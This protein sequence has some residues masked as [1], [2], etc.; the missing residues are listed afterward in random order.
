MKDI[1]FIYQTIL[2]VANNNNFYRRML[3]NFSCNFS[4][5]NMSFTRQEN[6]S[7]CHL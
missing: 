4:L 7:R 5:K 3:Q 2:K 6:K 1:R